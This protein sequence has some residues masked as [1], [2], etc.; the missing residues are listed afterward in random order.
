MKR[1]FLSLLTFILLTLS[2]YA[3]NQY[4]NATYGFS[5]IPP[6]DWKIYAELKNDEANKMAIID[7]GMPTIYSDLEKSNIENAV[8]I[9]ALAF[10]K[11]NSIESLIKVDFERTKKIRTSYD[12]VENEQNPTIICYSIQNKLEYKSKSV[13]FFKNN[14]G[15]IVSFT[16]TPGTYDKNVSKFNEFLKTVTF[17]TPLKMDSSQFANSVKLKFNGVYYGTAIYKNSDGK[18]IKT[19]LY[20]KFFD[21]GSVLAK[22]DNVGEPKEIIEKLKNEKD[23]DK[24]GKFNRKGSV[25]LF[26]L[27]NID[28]ISKS[29]DT[30]QS[31]FFYCK[32]TDENKLYLQITFD[33]DNMQTSWFDFYEFK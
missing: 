6:S 23:Y 17:F 2:Q 10:E 1:I 32:L 12:S 15:Y 21:D 31:D 30:S 11:I 20:L 8:S 24:K 22:R 25:L 14:I 4:K 28:K 26:E 16:A 29:I 3:Q 19:H 5:A 9:T 7:W 27:K 33:S 13:Y 18:N